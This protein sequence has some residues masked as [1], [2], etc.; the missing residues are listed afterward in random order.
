M[1]FADQ[2]LSVEYLLKNVG[3]LKPQV[4]PVPKDLDEQIARAKI[5]AMGMKIDAMTDEQRLYAN[6]WKAGT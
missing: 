6:S 3:S 4:Y 5:V 1:S 2:A